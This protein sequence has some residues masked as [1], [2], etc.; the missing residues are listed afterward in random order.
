MG[1]W[2]Y[3]V[4]RNGFWLAYQAEEGLLTEGSVVEIEITL[5]N[6]GTVWGK[7]L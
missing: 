1:C 2:R 7:V 4:D 3:G 6:I 5:R